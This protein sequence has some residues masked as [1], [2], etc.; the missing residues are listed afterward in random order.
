MIIDDYRFKQSVYDNSISI[1]SY[2]DKNVNPL[3]FIESISNKECNN[4]ILRIVPKIDSAEA[5]EYKYNKVLLPVYKK[6]LENK[7]N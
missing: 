4:A 3:K 2:N 7:E 6:L 1:Y 5:M